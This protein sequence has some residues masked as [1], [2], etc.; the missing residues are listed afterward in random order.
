M[1]STKSHSSV[2]VTLRLLLAFAL[3]PTAMLC[4]STPATSNASSLDTQIQQIMDRPEF[5]HSTFGIEFYSMDSGKVV[6]QRNASKLMV[7]GS[8]TKLVTE[9]TALELFGGDYRFHTFVY[10]TGS[11]NKKGVLEG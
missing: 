4:Q 10:R 9:G 3:M 5:A 8:T 6:Y 11:V 7:P 2:F 1:L